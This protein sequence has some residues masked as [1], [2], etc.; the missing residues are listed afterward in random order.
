M[1][2]LAGGLLA[3]PVYLILTLL[4]GLLP[5]MVQLLPRAEVVDGGVWIL[6]IVAM[7]AAGAL[8][9]GV[10]HQDDLLPRAETPAGSP[11]RTGLITGV[12]LIVLALLTAPFIGYLATTAILVGLAFMMIYLS[13]RWLGAAGRFFARSD[14]PVN[15]LAG[16]RLAADARSAARMSTLLGCC[17]FVIGALLHGVLSIMTDPGFQDRTG[18]YVTGFAM[19]IVGLLLVV[20]VAMGA[21]IVGVADQLVDQRRQLASLTAL[22]VDAAFLR[23]VITRQLAVV[24]GPALAIGS[25]AGLLF[26]LEYAT[27]A[28][29]SPFKMVYV[30]GALAVASGGCLFALAGGVLAG[31]LLRNQLRDA[32]DPENLRAA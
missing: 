17:G 14:D 24:G 18:F 4:L 7:T 6:V 11:S 21:L 10:L 8:L 30:L 28:G 26:G 31:Y 27:G 29:D 22:G 20:G 13:R 3:G 19:A 9:G 2:G 25:A 15:L 1:A 16:A 12:G 23:R 5:T 32:L